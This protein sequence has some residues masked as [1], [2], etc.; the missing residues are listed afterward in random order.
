M[1]PVFDPT[2]D[3]ELGL[4]EKGSDPEGSCVEGRGNLLLA[5]NTHLNQIASL[6]LART[7]VPFI[8]P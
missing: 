6:T 3:S 5:S 2:F 4:E 8:L 7:I 1:D